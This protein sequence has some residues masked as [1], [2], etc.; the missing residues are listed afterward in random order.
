MRIAETPWKIGSVLLI[1]TVGTLPLAGQSTA[2]PGKG[3]Q[4]F[5][6]MCSRC[7]GIEGGGGE[8]PNLNRPVLTR[9]NTDEALL[10]IIRDGI[11]DR[12]MPRT[13]RLTNTELQALVSFVRSL[14]SSG[15]V[16][17]A[18]ANPGSP[19]K[20]QAIY[21]RSGCASCHVVAGEGGT[22]GPELTSV[23]SHRAPDYLRQAIL[24]PGAVLPRG[25]MLIPGRGFN[26]F[27]PVRIVT[28]D[29]REVKGLRVNE[30]SFTI[31]VRDAGNQLYSFRKAD[32]QE[33][34]KQFGKSLMPE[35]QG[36]LSDSEMVDLV[37]YLSSLGA[38]L[39]GAR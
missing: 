20:G 19:E 39:G 32:L 30:D 16:A 18:L 17:G 35:Y 37:A 12:G 29:G 1:L 10:A 34:E 3:K 9:A 22:L 26:E 15:A 6:G 5:L 23:G 11:P 13:R 21:K 38:S 2:D 33:L 36:R 27:L 7:H 14:R 4:L 28:R 8:G 25:T 24:D 31:Q